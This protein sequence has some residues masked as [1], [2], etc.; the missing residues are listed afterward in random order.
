MAE[1]R[2]QRRLA[3]ILAADVAGYGRLMEADEAGTLAALRERRKDVLA[4]LL[5][6]HQGRIVKEMGDGVLVEFASAVNAVLCGVELQKRMAAANAP[7]PETRHIVWRIGINLGDVV[8][9][10]G[11]LYGDGVNVAARLQALIEPGGICVSAKVRDEVDRKINVAFEDM[12]EQA[13]K[14]MIAPV[15]LYRLR[16]EAPASAPGHITLP[17]P[18]KPSIAVLPF[19]NLSGD[20]EQQYF[21]DGITEDII[22]DLSKVSGLFVIARNSAFTYRGRAVNVQEVSRALGVRYVLEGSVRKAGNRVRIAAQLVDGTTGG[23]LWA[24]RYD[25]DLTDI[26]AVQDEVTREIVA[27]LALKLTQGEQ[28]RL[29]RKGTDNLEAYDYYL[30]GRQLAWRRSKEANDE[31]RVLLERAIALDPQFTSAYAMLAGVHLL[32]YANRWRSQPEESHRTAHELAQR[33][34]ALDDDAPE[35]HWVLGLVYLAPGQLDR[36][37][38]EARKALGLDPNFAWAHSLLGQALHYAGRSQEAIE[39]LTTAMRLDPNDQDPFLHFLAQAYFGL[40]RYEEAAANLRRR[41]VR[42]PD[43]DLS[44]VLLAACY[45]H[46]GRAEEARALWREVLQINPDY[47]FEYHRRRLPYEDPIDLERIA[48]GLRKAGLP[49]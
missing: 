5:A 37:M 34:V 22:T 43:T 20:P 32:D 18:D 9:E 27:A 12:G 49:A 8:V 28:R 41:I 45:G 13:L 26:F 25:R 46:L 31:A 29:E 42:K 23:H 7:L 10:G 19:D 38:A 30:R 15:R 47:S 33:A 39:P 36:S 24:E 16:N 14:N 48:D 11:D 17:L 21:S 40:G 3:A 44:R 2:A 1:E 4:P 6:Q 35:A